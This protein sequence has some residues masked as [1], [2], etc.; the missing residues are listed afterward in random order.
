MLFVTYRELNENNPNC[1]QCR[2]PPE[3]G[4]SMAVLSPVAT[5]R[6]EVRA[7]TA[8]I[9]WQSVVATLLAPLGIV[10][11]SLAI[12]A[13]VDELPTSDEKLAS[14]L[15]IVARHPTGTR[16]GFL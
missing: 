2:C 16:L 12:P 4:G 6:A 5:D 8:T 1:G 3:A 14:I 11:A 10:V 9:A 13:G 15:D 7:A